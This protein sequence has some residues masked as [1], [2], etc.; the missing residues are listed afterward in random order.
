MENRTFTRRAGL[1]LIIWI[2]VAFIVSTVPLPHLLWNLYL[3]VVYAGIGLWFL[4]YSVSYMRSGAERAARRRQVDPSTLDYTG[5]WVTVRWLGF[6]SF[7]VLGLGT[8]FIALI[9]S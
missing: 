4:M 7:E 2:G 5:R 9:G 8:V 6:I 3:A 1:G